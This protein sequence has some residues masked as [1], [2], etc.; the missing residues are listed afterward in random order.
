M[1]ENSVMPD[2]MASGRPPQVR[3]RNS[4]VTRQEMWVEKE[5]TAV[6]NQQRQQEENSLVCVTAPPQPLASRTFSC[7]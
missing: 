7:D 4:S 1:N 6:R 3:A 2:R 5:M